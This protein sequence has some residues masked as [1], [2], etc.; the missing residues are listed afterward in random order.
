[1][2]DVGEGEGQRDR[3]MGHVYKQRE[4]ELLCLMTFFL[5]KTYCMCL[6]HKRLC[7]KNHKSVAE[8]VEV[9]LAVVSA[10]TNEENR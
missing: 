6:L 4:E 8:I 3:Q 9:A 7:F 10:C 2:G 5:V 1:M